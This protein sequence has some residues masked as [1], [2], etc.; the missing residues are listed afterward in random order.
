MSFVIEI[1]VKS[2]YAGLKMLKFDLSVFSHSS[3]QHSFTQT[4]AHI[5]TCAVN[6]AAV[7]MC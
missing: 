1:L 4:M 7:Q 2:C 3:S 6:E 5:K